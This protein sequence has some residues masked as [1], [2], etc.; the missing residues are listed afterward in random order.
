LS[1]LTTFAAASIRSMS[2]RACE[3]EW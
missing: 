1:F 2:S 3:L